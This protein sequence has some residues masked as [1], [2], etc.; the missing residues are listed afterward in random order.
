M[1]PPIAL[2]PP[3]EAALAV[4]CSPYHESARVQGCCPYDDAA[5]ELGIAAQPAVRHGCRAARCPYNDTARELGVSAQGSAVRPDRRAER[6]PYRESARVQGCKPTP[7]ETRNQDQMQ[8]GKEGGWRPRAHSL[9]R[10]QWP[11]RQ[12]RQA[13]RREPGRRSRRACQGCHAQEWRKRQRTVK[14]FAQWSIPK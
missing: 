7:H 4:G 1:Q 11:G 14:K 8:I 2:T 3:H 13:Y 6:C 12:S 5:R 9:C 10:R